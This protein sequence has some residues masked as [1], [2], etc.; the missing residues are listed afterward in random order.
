MNFTLAYQRVLII[1]LLIKLALAYFLPMSGDEAYFIV[2][3]RHL[4]YGYYDHPPMVGWML[5]AMRWLG[6]SEVLMRLPAVVFSTLM[7]IGIFRLLKPWDA[8]RA[9]WVAMV[10]LMSPINILNVL[11]TTDTPLIFFVFVSIYMMVRAVRSE[12]RL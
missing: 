12:E 2:W 4:D 1:T 11:I 5:Y 9:A 10:F 6:D 3:A 7:G 8:E